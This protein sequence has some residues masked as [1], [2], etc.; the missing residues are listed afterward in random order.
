MIKGKPVRSIE[1]QRDL[2]VQVHKSLKVAVQVEKVAKKAY[3]MLA[4]IG[5]GIE[6]K[7]WSLM[8]QLYRT[9]VRPHL[10]YCVQFWSPYYRK[11]VETLERVQRRFTR[12]L[13]GMEGLGY[14]ERLKKLGLFSL[15][16]RRLRGD[17]IE[18]YKIMKGIDRVNRGKLFPIIETRRTRG[19]GLKVR[20]E[21]YNTDIRG[22]FFTQRVV[23]V[24]N[25]LPSKVV[26]AN[27]LESFKSNLDRH[28]TE[29]EM[30]GYRRLF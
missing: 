17:L 22:R 23:G 28:M 5:R 14:E 29:L 15:E 6:Y 20:G 10:E 2:G 4:F 18:V 11:D 8:L 19:H 7:S 13:P 12:M 3:G 27:T 30:G 25:A 16:R 9:L 1:S 21:R 26:E 24:W